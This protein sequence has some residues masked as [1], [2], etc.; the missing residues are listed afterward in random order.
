MYIYSSHAWQKNLSERDICTKYIA[1]ALQLTGRDIDKEIMEDVSF[2]EKIISQAYF[3]DSPGRKPAYCREIAI[4]RTRDA[5][6]K[7]RHTN[8]QCENSNNT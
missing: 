3:S 8:R 1:P 2:A 4:T 5:I 7:G 6:A